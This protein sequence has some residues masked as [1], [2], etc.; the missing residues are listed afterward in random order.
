MEEGVEGAGEEVDEGFAGEMPEE[1][2]WIR[3]IQR[4]IL[5][6]CITLLDHPLQD[7]QDQSPII[8]GLAILIIKG[9]KGMACRNNYRMIGW[10]DEPRC[11]VRQATCGKDNRYG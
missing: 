5:R 3:Q 6:F 4:E 7:N 9:V 11:H 1:V 8:S 2:K 10:N